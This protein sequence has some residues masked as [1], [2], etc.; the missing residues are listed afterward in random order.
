MLLSL[1]IVL[2]ANDRLRGTSFFKPK[3]VLPYTVPQGQFSFILEAQ[4]PLFVR[5]SGQRS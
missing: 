5:G 3:R 4:L 1:K 2:R